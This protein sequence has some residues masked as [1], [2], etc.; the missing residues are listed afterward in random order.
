MV[1]RTKEGPERWVP[2]TVVA[3]CRWRAHDQQSVADDVEL[4][5][6]VPA[7]V[8]APVMVVGREAVLDGRARQQEFCGGEPRPTK[9]ER[10]P[11]SAEHVVGVF[12]VTEVREH[13][14]GAC[15]PRASPQRR[16]RTASR[17]AERET[18]HNAATR[19]S[20]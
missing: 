9:H 4:L 16:A 15:P 3:T 1:H 7:L 13:E 2:K 10:A 19:N 20:E 18:K 14:R 11:G 12:K 6:E 17:R 8:V 5:R